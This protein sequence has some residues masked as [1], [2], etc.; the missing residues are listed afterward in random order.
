MLIAGWLKEEEKGQ[1][2]RKKDRS[3]TYSIYANTLFMVCYPEDAD[4]KLRGG[5]EVSVQLWRRE[6]L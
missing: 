3:G 5:S 1:K 6:Y 2:M 4:L